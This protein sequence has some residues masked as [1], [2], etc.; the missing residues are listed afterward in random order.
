VAIPK[1]V[2]I[3][4][5]ILYLLILIPF[6]SGYTNE[7][8]MGSQKIIL[9]ITS[10]EQDDVIFFDVFP[11]YL[12]VQGRIY[13]AGIRNVTV[14]FDTETMACGIISET[15]VDVSCKFSIHTGPDHITITIA[16]DQGNTISDTRNITLI[17]NPP[18]P[19]SVWISGYI[20][21]AN[22]TPLKDARLH[23]ETTEPGLL[24][25]VNTTSDING[26]YSMKK[27]YG[28]QQKITIQKAGYQTL[29]REV[30]FQPHTN[31]INF[32]LVREDQYP[33]PFTISTV[34]FALIAGILIFSL[35]RSRSRV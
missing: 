10:P 27:T 14:N 2:I 22:G 26:R 5:I 17:S 20:F 32:T 29:V 18:A 15:F 11:A 35:G 34:I 33:L 28:T 7:M 9:N 3:T 12:L 16:D 4:G 23:F 25:S 13:G 19:G 21:D 24:S 8:N 31:T 6:T 30:K 1:F